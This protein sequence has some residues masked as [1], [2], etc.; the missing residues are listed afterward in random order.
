MDKQRRLRIEREKK[1][2][3]QGYFC[4]L[5]YS[6]ISLMITIFLG[7]NLHLFLKILVAI[8]SIIL[9]IVVYFLIEKNFI[10]KKSRTSFDRR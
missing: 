5:N 1:R 10:K 7:W 3:R 4:F 9:W 2:K 8:L 6:I